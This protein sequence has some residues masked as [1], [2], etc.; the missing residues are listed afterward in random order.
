MRIEAELK[1]PERFP[2]FDGSRA[3]PALVVEVVT[4]GSTP[5]EIRLQGEI[6]IATLPVLDETL[7][8]MVDGNNG[9]VVVDLAEVD[10][11]GVAGLGALCTHARRLRQRGDRLVISSPST[12]TRRVIDILGVSELLSVPAPHARPG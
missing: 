4:D 2:S 3:I 6:D 7:S 5:P 10:F 8:A 11:I 1:A 12:F 9:D